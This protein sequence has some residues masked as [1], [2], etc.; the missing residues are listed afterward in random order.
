MARLEEEDA[1]TLRLR[2]K[3]LEAQLEEQVYGA[4]DRLRT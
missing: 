3:S 2:V 4:I 1:Q